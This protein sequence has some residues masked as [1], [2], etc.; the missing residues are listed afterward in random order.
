MV[1]DEELTAKQY[2][3]S[4]FWFQKNLKH[5]AVFHLFFLESI[6]A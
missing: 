2:K 4:W 1:V 6:Q 5:L 3:Q